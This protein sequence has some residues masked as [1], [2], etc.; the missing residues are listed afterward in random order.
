MFP[1][2]TRGDVE[3]LLHTTIQI[4]N[5]VEHFIGLIEGRNFVMKEEN[6]TPFGIPTVQTELYQEK[7]ASLKKNKLMNPNIYDLLMKLVAHGFH[8]FPFLHTQSEDNSI[9]VIDISKRE[10]QDNL[11]KKFN[12]PPRFMRVCVD[13]VYDIVVQLKEPTDKSF[14]LDA[15]RA[16]VWQRF[17][18][19]HLQEKKEEMKVVEYS[20]TVGMSA[21]QLWLRD[22][23]LLDYHRYFV[24]KGFQVLQDFVG[25]TEDD[26]LTYFPFLKIGDSRRLTKSVP[27][28]NDD[29]IAAFEKKAKG[30]KTKGRKAKTQLKHDLRAEYAVLPLLPPI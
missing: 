18:L 14:E 12:N 24:D 15:I 7:L 16:N 30:E 29:V 8:S 6:A 5:F 3:R 13:T 17:G 23:Y 27:F 11:I 2:L 26:I 28:L 20:S 9:R 21:T 10:L 22:I 19:L 25:L 4:D 1:D